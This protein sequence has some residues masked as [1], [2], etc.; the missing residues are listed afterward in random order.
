MKLAFIDL[1][2]TGTDPHAHAPVQIAGLLVNGSRE[3]SFDLRVRP[4]PGAAVEQA[5]LNVHGLAEEQIQAYPEPAKVHAELTDLLAKHVD[6]YDRADK[7]H[8][9][10]YNAGFDADFLRAFFKHAGDPYFGS[11]F[12]WPPVDVAVLAMDRLAEERHR[13]PDF[14]LGTVASHLGLEPDGD[15]HDALVDIRLTR[16]VWERVSDVGQKMVLDREREQQEDEDAHRAAAEIERA[17]QDRWAFERAQDE[18]AA[19]AERFQGGPD[20]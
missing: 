10:A 9:I 6:R 18:A 16:R 13:L 2:T 12:W 4:R 20:G 8:F 1:E 5:A 11:W 7:F 14:K 15:L 19:D 3:D 17:E